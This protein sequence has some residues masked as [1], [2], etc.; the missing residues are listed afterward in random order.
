MVSVLTPSIPERAGM[1]EEACASVQAQTYRGFRHHVF[2]DEDHRGCAWTVN[3]LAALAE[4]EW[5]FI[6]AD[7]DLM[8]PGC[9]AAHLAASGGADIVYA[10]PLV[11]GA[12][13]EG[14]RQGFPAIPSASLIRTSLWRQLGGYDENRQR[15][16]DRDFYVRAQAAGARVVRVAGE[17]TWVYRIHAGSKSWQ[18]MEQTW[19]A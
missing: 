1:L 2:V 4:G 11:W 7:D 6:L 8:L 14:Y 5:L 9:L 16:E 17:P 18:G 12:S 10:P 3:Q 15:E 13:A 19:A